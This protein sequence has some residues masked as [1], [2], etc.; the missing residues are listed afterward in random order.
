MR[1]WFAKSLE[2][3]EMFSADASASA[4]ETPLVPSAW[5]EACSAGFLEITGVLLAAVPYPAFLMDGEGVI[6]LCNASVKML[7]SG[8]NTCL[9]GMNVRDFLAKVGLPDIS[10]RR[11]EKGPWEEHVRAGGKGYLLS[12]CPLF[13]GGEAVGSLVQ[14]QEQTSPAAM[15]HELTTLRQ[16]LHELSNYLEF[17]FDGLCIIDSETTILY[18]NNVYE[19]ITGLKREEMIGRTMRH[20]VDQGVF[21]RSVSMRVLETRNP[22]TL[23]LK[24]NTGK[25]VLVSANPLFD[26]SNK[27]HRVVCS[28]RDITELNR[29]Q[30]ELDSAETLKAQY[31]EELLALKKGLAPSGKVVFRSGAM[32]RIIELALRL[33]SVDSTVLLR[34]ESGVGKEVIADFIHKNSLRRDKPFLKINCAAI[35][36]ALLESELFGYARGAFTGANREGKVGIFE[37]ATRGSLLLDE[38]G[39]LPLPLQVKL[40]RVIQ[41]KTVRRIGDTVDRPVDVRII[42]ATHRDLAA[43]TETGE[44]RKDLF[45]RLNVVPIWI[46]PLRE[47]KEDILLLVQSVLQKLNERY[48]TEKVLHPQVVPMLLGYFWPGNVRE[49]ENILERIFVTSPGKIISASDLPDDLFQDMGKRTPLPVEGKSLKELMDNFEATILRHYFFEYKTTREVAAA[50]GIHQSNIVRK[51]QRLGLHRTVRDKEKHE[52]EHTDKSI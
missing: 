9:I 5:R 44:F 21:D 31:E 28:I 3:G 37:A 25:S 14:L 22:A 8:Q 47:R 34:G 32:R 48:A 52:G 19:R 4:A 27:I 36:E 42:T 11:A 33:G 20:L 38:V 29:L 46:P 12:V 41:N 35:P 50:L 49:L 6:R 45:Y 2:A 23:P 7:A 39:D 17:S 40:L 26:E 18:L 10:A 13:S 15:Q 51:A 16:H 30:H 24:L 43:M 1:E